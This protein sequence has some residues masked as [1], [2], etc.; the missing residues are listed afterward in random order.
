MQTFGQPCT[1]VTH[2]RPAWR[3]PTP[4]PSPPAPP[5]CI[6]AALSCRAQHLGS[7][8]AL[9]RLGGTVPALVFGPELGDALVAEAHR[10]GW[11]ANKNRHAERA[12]AMAASEA[13]GA[14]EAALE[15]V[16]AFEYPLHIF[17]FA[18]TPRMQQRAEIV[19]PASPAQDEQHSLVRG[20][21][22]PRKTGMEQL[23]ERPAGTRANGM[24]LSCLLQL[25]SP[26]PDPPHGTFPTPSRSPAGGAAPGAPGGGGSRRRPVEPPCTGGAVPVLRPA[27]WRGARAAAERRAPAPA[28]AP[29]LPHR[30]LGQ[31]ERRH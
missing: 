27:G 31:G 3:C 23:G 12:Q 16:D 21:R 17:C 22:E 30:R 25:C 10:P 5:R 18:R 8:A 13:F 6:L 29:T 11:E 14:V 2:A 7:D 19:E 4:S 1:V 15:G 9:G 24:R 28:R 26:L 20:G